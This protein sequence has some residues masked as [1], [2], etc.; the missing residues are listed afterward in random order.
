MLAIKRLWALVL[1]VMLSGCSLF[2]GASDTGAERV[3]LARG[4]QWA[5]PDG[6]LFAD[7]LH[8]LQ[9]VR[10]TYGDKT[11]DLLV[12]TENIPG[13]GL[14]MAGL[15][16]SGQLLLQ[17]TFKSG[18]V[19]G[20][21]SPLLGDKIRLPYMMSD[22]L[23]ANADADKLR[24]YLQECGLTIQDSPAQRKI[25]KGRAVL[26]QVDKQHTQLLYR[27]LALGYAMTVTTLQEDQ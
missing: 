10:A 11:F 24:P 7:Q 9:Q 6:Q 20:W 16:P 25:L 19:S 3:Y 15:T 26:I 5:L 21:V 14:V 13:E 27:N 23:L 18:K 1:V 2:Q 22:F 8:M 12:Q 17:M 4:V